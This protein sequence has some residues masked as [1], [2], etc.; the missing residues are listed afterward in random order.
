MYKID[1]HT[2][3]ITPS[4][5]IETITFKE[6]DNRLY[7]YNYDGTHFRLFREVLELIQFFEMGTEPHY[8]FSDEADLDLFLKDYVI[9]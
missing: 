2:E 1:S 6:N 5:T 3:Y 8:H 7:I 9:F 4:R